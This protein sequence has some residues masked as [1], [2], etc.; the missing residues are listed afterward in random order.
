MIKRTDSTDN[1]RMYDN[2]R[3]AFNGTNFVLYPN[4]PNIEDQANDH[5]DY[6]SNGFKLRSNNNNA[7][8]GTYI[9]ACWMESPF[10]TAN[11]K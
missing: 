5:L 1:W 9:F 11:A 2:A 4:L 7:S 3:G 8:G 6:L 10:T